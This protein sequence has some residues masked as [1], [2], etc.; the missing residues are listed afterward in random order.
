MLLVLVSK[1]LVKSNKTFTLCILSLFVSQLTF[2]VHNPPSLVINKSPRELGWTNKQGRAISKQS[3]LASL[4][5]QSSKETTCILYNHNPKNTPSFY[6]RTDTFNFT[7]ALEQYLYTRFT[8]YTHMLIN[9]L[10]NLY[11]NVV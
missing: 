10:C 8:L 9:L 4:A 7:Y 5:R 11:T 6:C 1:H 3:L 2:T